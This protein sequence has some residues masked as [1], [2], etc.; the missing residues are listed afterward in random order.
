MT[1]M[2]WVQAEQGADGDTLPFESL[3]CQQNPHTRIDPFVGDLSF[4]TP[5]S[6]QPCVLQ[7]GR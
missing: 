5:L 2:R 4:F 3:L 7:L 6:P 1:A